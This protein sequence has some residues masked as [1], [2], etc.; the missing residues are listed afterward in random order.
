MTK[1]TLS[2]LSEKLHDIDIVMLSTHA[3]DGGISTRPMNSAAKSTYDGTSHYFAI[4]DAHLVEEIAA[5]RKVGLSLQ[6]RGGIVGQRPFMMTV[7]GEAER[8]RDREAMRTHWSQ[9]LTRWFAQDLDTPGLVL[10][11]VLAT[12]IRYWDGDEAGDDHG[13]IVIPGST[14]LS[15]AAVTLP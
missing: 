6:G 1:L 7:Q 10:I 2:E 15:E 11:R 9:D 8:I 12:S 13:E 3:A 4:E 14:G 5:N